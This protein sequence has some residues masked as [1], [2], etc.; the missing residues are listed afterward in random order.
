M[1]ATVR[2]SSMAPTFRDGDR[3]YAFRRPRYRV[4]DVIVFDVTSPVA[5]GA[6]QIGDAGRNRGT[7]RNRGTG[8][9]LG[10]GQARDAGRARGGADPAWRIKRVTAVA[11]DPAPDWAAGPTV[12]PGCLVVDGDNPVSQGSRQL[13]YVR[14]AQVLGAVRGLP[15]P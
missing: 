1:A 3:V 12:P 7:D 15:A 4:G 6:D 2:G 8:R 13:G 5:P 14:A 10:A 9:A 11:G